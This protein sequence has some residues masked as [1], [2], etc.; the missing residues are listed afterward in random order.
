MN[1]KRVSHENGLWAKLLTQWEAEATG[2]EENFSDYAPDALSV[3]RPLAEETQ[4]KNAGV[5]AVCD[6]SHYS[7]L[8]QLNAAFLPGYDGKVLR[9]RHIVHS[10][11]FDYDADLT[12]DDY[13]TVLA[14][15]FIG[16]F[17]ASGAEMPAPYVKFHFRSPAERSFFDNLKDL[18]GRHDAFASVEMR[19]SWLYIGK[20]K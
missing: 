20:K 18:L 3:L 7:L 1:F 11:R 12:I 5:Y 14:D 2:F 15:L 6:D 19:G 13:A 17:D 9:V 4:V 10:P 16:V 8:C